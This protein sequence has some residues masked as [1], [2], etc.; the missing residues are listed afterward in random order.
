MK[1]GWTGG[2]YSLYRMIFGFYLFAHFLQLIPWSADLFSHAG[3]LHEG[4]LSPLLHLFP[5]ILA[6]ND[7]PL[8]ATTLA[9]LGAV[10]SY[11]FM[12]GRWDRP[13]AFL[14]WY[15]LACFL[16]RNPLISNPSLPFVGWLLLAHLFVPKIR[17]TWSMT[18][19]IFLSAWIVMS[20]SYSYSGI[21]KLASPSWL[22]GTALSYLLENPLVRCNAIREFLLTAPAPLLK[23]MTWGALALEILFAPLALFR[24]LRPWI[25][26]A[27]LLMHISL[28]KLLNF[29]DLTWGMIILHFF[30]FDPGWIKPRPMPEKILVFYDGTCGFCHSFVRFVLSE[31]RARLPFRFAHLQTQADSIAVQIREGEILFKS[32]AVIRV[33]SHLGGVWKF[34]AFLLSL[35]ATKLSDWVYDLIARFRHRIFKKPKE[36]CPILPIEMREFFES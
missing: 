4:N 27:M 14:L 24:R 30:T 23:A 22:D 8:M 16:C 10:A 2:Q 15:I 26:T 35:I 21:L 6:F 20:L 17:M 36:S 5:N 13:A 18:P 19:S 28:L 25:W 7:S 33:L 9:I 1:N 29:A 12:I 3:M 11:R 34:L 31:N 32:K